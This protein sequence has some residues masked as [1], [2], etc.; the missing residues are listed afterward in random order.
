MCVYVYTLNIKSANF[1]PGKEERGI[2]THCNVQKIV[3][4]SWFRDTVVVKDH[5]PCTLF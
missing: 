5:L 4:Q 1:L 2:H 3:F